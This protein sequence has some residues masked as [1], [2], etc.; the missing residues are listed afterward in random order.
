MKHVRFTT[1][2]LALSVLCGCNNTPRLA[3]YTSPIQQATDAVCAKRCRF[4]SAVKTNGELIELAGTYRYAMNANITVHVLQE[5]SYVS[6][7]VLT[8]FIVIGNPGLTGWQQAK[9]GDVL[10][11][12]VHLLFNKIGSGWK[13]A[14]STG[15]L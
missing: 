14:P 5:L 7:H 10:R 15:K 11:L 1:L 9:P 3:N 12:P 6:P 4:V 8:G 13:L 2:S